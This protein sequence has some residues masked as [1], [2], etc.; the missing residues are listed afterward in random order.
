MATAKKS[1]V[2]SQRP[3]TGQYARHGAPSSAARV[4]KRIERS[5]G[6]YWSVD[7]FQDLNAS[8]ISRTLARLAKDGVVVR[9]AP[10]VYYKGRDTAIGKSRP[11]PARMAGQSVKHYGLKPAGISAANALGLTTQIPRTPEYATTN[12]NKPSSVDGRVHVLRPSSRDRLDAREFALLEVI[13]TRGKHTDGEPAVF[14]RRITLMVTSEFDFSRLVKAAMDEPARV[15]A[16][17][18]AIG[19]HGGVSEKK[20]RPLR[21]TLREGSSYDFGKFKALPTAS[22]WQAK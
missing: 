18:G 3:G 10:G 8:G 21:K 12:R 13:R 17:L 9:V 5:P 16:I 1:A 22:N 15:R 11:S 20:L 14:V 4:R 19:E 6:R 7:D 2:K